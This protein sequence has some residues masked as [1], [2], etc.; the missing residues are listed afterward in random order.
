[1]RRKLKTLKAKSGH[2]ENGAPRQLLDEA[3]LRER[4]AAA[5]IGVTPHYDPTYSGWSN[6]GRPRDYAISLRSIGF[7]PN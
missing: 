5:T 4:R 1:M 3:L 2:S 6:A 7:V